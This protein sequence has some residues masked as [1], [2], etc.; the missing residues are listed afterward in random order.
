M[1]CRFRWLLLDAVGTDVDFLDVS[2]R[3]LALAY[4]V[5]RPAGFRLDTA[6][7]ARIEGDYIEE[8]NS[9]VEIVSPLGELHKYSTIEFNVVRFQLDQQPLAIRLTNP[10]RSSSKLFKELTLLLGTTPREPRI[11]VRSCLDKWLAGRPDAIVRDMLLSDVTV[12]R[13]TRASIRFAGLDDVRN[14]AAQFL[15]GQEPS[16]SC[17]T[18]EF[19]DGDT[20]GRFELRSNCTAIVN[21]WRPVQI[22]EDLWSTF[23]ASQA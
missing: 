2:K 14:D 9:D 5:G 8:V 6:T 21:A 7:S 16:I 23:L 1:R 20:Y 18:V 10:P 3:M 13:S 22:A 19:V 17:V 4:G 15:S 11:N 12:G